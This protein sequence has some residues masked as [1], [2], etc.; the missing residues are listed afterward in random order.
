MSAITARQIAKALPS[1]RLRILFACACVRQVWRLLRDP[2]SR[3][4]VELAEA[5]ADGQASP[6]EAVATDAANAVRE[7]PW[8][9]LRESSRAAQA[10]LTTAE[11]GWAGATSGSDEAATRAAQAAVGAG[12]ALGKA[13]WRLEALL[14]ELTPPHNV[15]LAPAFRLWEEGTIPNM[16]SVIY[17]GDLFER[18]PILADALEEA[19]CTSTEILTHLRCGCIHAKGCWTLEAIFGNRARNPNIVSPKG[20]LSLWTSG[21]T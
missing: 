6:D 11:G 17:E 16:A 14:E 4:A 18:M 12:A 9:P 8:G 15:H 21:A 5:I 1:A 2:R 20:T 3:A 7:S 10:A 19:G 13:A